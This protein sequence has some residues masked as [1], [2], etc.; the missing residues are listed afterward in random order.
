MAS[1]VI[2][3]E[4]LLG[5]AS[6]QL[7]Q[8]LVGKDMVRLLARLDPGLARPERLS[9]IAIG[10]RSPAS[11]LLDSRLRA[12]LLL[13]LPQ[14]SAE[15][16]A[17]RLGLSGP[18]YEA[19]SAMS[20]RRHSK[21]A[22]ELL[23]FFSLSDES[24][25]RNLLPSQ[26]SVCPKH[27]LFPHQRLASRRV[28]THLE[29]EPH[30][31][32]L[33]MPTGSGKT[34]TAMSIIANILNQGEPKLVV[35]LAHSEELCEQ[36]VEEF[37][38]AWTCLGS[39]PVD[40]QRWWGPHSLSRPIIRDGIVIAGLQKAHS[41]VRTSIV[42]IGTIAGHVALVVMDE[43]HQAVAPTYQ[44]ILDVLTESGRP[45][46]LLGLTATPGRTWNDI[47]EDERL[48]NFFYRRKV[49][50]EVEGY[51]N[52]VRFLIDEGYLAEAEFVQLHYTAR[53]ELPPQELQALRDSLDIPQ[54]IIESLA[55]D[56]Q[57][58][59]LILSQTETMCRRHNRIIVFAATKDHAVVLATVLRARGYWSHA[60]TGETPPSD[61]ARIIA[62]FRT[63]SGEPRVIVNYGVLTTGF[64]A[65]QTSA[66]IIAR[67]TK[68]LVLF[69]Q[70][71]GR[72]T[73][74]EKAGGNKRAEV[75]TVVDTRLPGFCNMADAFENW[76]DVW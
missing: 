1:V 69:S 75:A 24:E 45:A 2:T 7:L 58:N 18:P 41:S 35:W 43:A 61:R 63:A 13:L 12:E 44:M 30:R 29:A 50:L 60:V 39:R 22:T 11:M 65:P 73:R 37:R 56:E 32:M 55:A 17:Q 36:A 47:D 15:S 74:G 28:L 71:V 4:E 76:E 57:R 27:A 64:D 14:S 3:F 19:L 16:L 40:I 48:A 20:L 72:A 31:V 10:L 52:P 53:A 5:R 33:H 8:K 46:P 9:E 42:D 68:S 21:R 23:N 6:D 34:R 25:Q 66:A 51:E 62:D 26:E 38:K 54:S 67:P 49:S 70:M 59:L